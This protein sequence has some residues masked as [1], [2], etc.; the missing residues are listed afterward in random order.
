MAKMAK[1]KAGTGWIWLEIAGMTG[2]GWKWLE[3]I[4]MAGNGWKGL[5]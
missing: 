3:W 2:N 5:K 1:K 4:L